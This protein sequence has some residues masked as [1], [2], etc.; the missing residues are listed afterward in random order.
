MKDEEFGEMINLEHRELMFGKD[1]LNK[2][3]YD[4]ESIRKGIEICIEKIKEMDRINTEWFYQSWCG[5]DC[6]DVNDIMRELNRLLEK[7]GFDL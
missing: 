7:D 5:H 3:E 4:I 6:L 1:G 2:N